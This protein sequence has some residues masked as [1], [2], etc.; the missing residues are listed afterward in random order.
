MWLVRSCLVSSGRQA[1]I[2]IYSIALV[3][4]N[5]HS[6]MSFVFRSDKL[7]LNSLPFSLSTCKFYDAFVRTANIL[8][9]LALSDWFFAIKSSFWRW[10]ASK[11]VD[12]SAYFFSDLSN[13]FSIAVII[14]LSCFWFLGAGTSMICEWECDYCSLLS[15]SSNS[16]TLACNFLMIPLEKC[17]LL[18]N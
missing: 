7:T 8:L 9:L 15:S 13:S 5:D 10:S 16:V 3:S 6:L 2:M 17:D 1:V 4:S 18:A 12:N 14:P 11:R